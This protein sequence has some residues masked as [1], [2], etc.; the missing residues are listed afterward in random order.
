MTFNEAEAA[1]GV[2]DIDRTR[3]IDVFQYILFRASTTNFVLERDNESIIVDFR[4]RIVFT[5]YDKD[6]NNIL[7]YSELR[8]MIRDMAAG[9]GHVN[10]LL[11]KMG[12]RENTSC[13]VQV[14]A[15]RI[16]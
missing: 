10:W 8:K 2:F 3:D 9:D 5:I 4:L 1:F 11:E 13:D 14:Y 12:I 16:F 15:Q 7:E 6:R